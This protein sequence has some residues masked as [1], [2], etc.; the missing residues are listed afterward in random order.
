MVEKVND[1]VVRNWGTKRSQGQIK[2]ARIGTKT[3]ALRRT[4]FSRQVSGLFCFESSSHRS[5]RNNS[6][7]LNVFLTTNMSL[8]LSLVVQVPAVN[9]AK[10]QAS[11]TFYFAKNKY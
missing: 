4:M 7:F 1:Y 8:R 10:L 2:R 3:V 5:E 9:A 6:N 11:I